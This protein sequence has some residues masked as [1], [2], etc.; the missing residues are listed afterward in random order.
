MTEQNDTQRYETVEL[1]LTDEEL[2]TYMKCAHELDITFNELVNRAMKYAI[3]QHKLKEQ[4]DQSSSKT[5][6]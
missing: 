5:D 3:E 2:L 1:E 6:C 4:N